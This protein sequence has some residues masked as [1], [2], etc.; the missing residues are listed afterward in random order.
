MYNLIYPLMPRNRTGRTLC[1][2]MICTSCLNSSVSRICR[3]HTR[4]H[5]SNL[6]SIS[7]LLAIKSSF[8]HNSLAKMKRQSRQ[9]ALSH[10][11]RYDE[12]TIEDQKE[13]KSKGADDSGV[14]RLNWSNNVDAFILSETQET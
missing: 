6:Y 7:F 1:G 9:K 12:I 4:G 10:L 14:M 8:Q 13:D 5:I 2:I 3:T 11:K